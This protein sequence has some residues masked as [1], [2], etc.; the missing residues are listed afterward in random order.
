MTEQAAGDEGEASG[1]PPPEPPPLEERR[2][3]DAR[4]MLA[5]GALVLV[6]YLP[7][8]RGSFVWD[9]D[10]N[11]VRNGNLRSL[12]G[13]WRIWSDPHASQQYYPLTHTTFWIN[14]ALG[15][16]SPLAYHLVNVALHVVSAILVFAVLRRLAVRGAPL[17][18]A[19]FALHPLNVESV[20]WVTERKNVLAGALGLASFL[21]YLRFDEAT[22]GEGDEPRDPKHVRGL[23]AISLGLFLLALLA[24]TAV[25][26]AP[27]VMLV[28]VL[29]LR[30][31]R[32]ARVARPLA[33]FFTL[34]IAAGLFTAWLERTHVGAHGADFAWSSPE[35]VA[36][37]GRIFL[38]YLQ[39]LFAPV[40]L[41][42]FYPRW[43]ISAS[44][45]AFLYA[46]G[47]LAVIGLALAARRRFGPGPLAAALA[48]AALLFPALGFFNVYFMRYSFVQNHFQ[49]FA[50]IPALALAAAA[51]DLA[52]E[53]LSRWKLPLAGVLSTLLAGLSFIQAS[54]FRD[55]ET[56]FLSALMKNPDAWVASYNLGLWYVDRGRPREAVV[57]HAAALRAKPDEPDV[58]LN[59]G[60]A[61]AGLGRTEEALPLFRKAAAM[62]PDHPETRLDLAAGLDLAG[63]PA[64]AVIAYREALRL[65]PGWTRAER[66]LAWLLA[67]T[68]DEQVR[69][70]AAAVELATRACARTKDTIA[71]CQDTLAAAE[72][73]SGKFEQAAARAAKAADLAKS[74][75]V[76]AQYRARARLY[77][78]KKPYIER[79]RRAPSSER[80]PSAPS[81]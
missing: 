12:A 42:F 29:L 2:R 54:T 1:A 37:A 26:V 52:F 47:A 78:D 28:V 55:Y 59:F 34:G 14:F 57:M 18:A 62:R 27:A 36:L 72:A 23:W 79:R 3:S 71:R 64:E 70:G 46:L 69:D 20:A 8:L 43:A 53:R 24:K 11:I 73:A 50:S 35:R 31:R 56:L 63:A 30:G 58:V 39:K 77:A 44:P 74:D 45:A 4:S 40:D 81:P 60:V 61:L 41:A 67:T 19:L 16:L 22:H 66:Q 49:Y 33:P 25:A 6:A 7:A 51:I 48:Y 38:F 32:L 15:G 76:A 5:L 65:R 17:A 68:E 80:A 21:F 75:P 13:L 9:D 10:K